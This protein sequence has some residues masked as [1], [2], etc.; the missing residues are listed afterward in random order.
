MLRPTTTTDMHSWEQIHQK[1]PDEEQTFGM[2]ISLLCQ[3]RPSRI[4]QARTEIRRL[5][6]GN[7]NLSNADALIQLAR[8]SQLYQLGVTDDCFAFG[9]KEIRHDAGALAY[10]EAA[11]KLVSHD[12]AGGLALLQKARAQNAKPEDALNW[13]LANARYLELTGDS[14]AKAAWIALGVA[15]PKNLGLQQTLLQVRS[16]NTD[17]DF[18]ARTIER[19]HS[20]TGDNNAMARTDFSLSAS[21]LSG[22]SALAGARTNI[23]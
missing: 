23:A 14:R 6:A 15:N 7:K 20:L 4:D 8:W 5:L 3:S 19:V 17:R 11:N 2:Y 1:L 9:T 12:P 22:K 18:L 21:V 13:D 10:A 16:I